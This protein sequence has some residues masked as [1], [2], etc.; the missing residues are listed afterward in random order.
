MHRM[1]AVASRLTVCQ[2]TQRQMSRCAAPVLKGPSGEHRVSDGAQTH[3]RRPARICAFA[4]AFVG[5]HLVVS[6]RHPKGHTM[7]SRATID[8]AA[9]VTEYAA[10]RPI[11]VN[12]SIMPTPPADDAGPAVNDTGDT[13]AAGPAGPQ[14]RR[15]QRKA[16]GRSEN[17][18]ARWLQIPGS[19]PI[20]A[21]SSVS[22]SSDGP[23]PSLGIALS[24]VNEADFGQRPMVATH[25]LQHWDLFTDAALA[26]CWI[27]CPG[28]K[29]TR[30]RWAATPRSPSRTVWRAATV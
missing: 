24:A 11:A 12:P 29:C 8:A 23:A 21:M 4:P 16:T 26:T 17:G 15:R 13:T 2:R 5:T 9:R 20:L 19:A 25:N 14:A 18:T 7:I 6:H 10:C 30:S 1:C 27:T 3:T 28:S 22:L